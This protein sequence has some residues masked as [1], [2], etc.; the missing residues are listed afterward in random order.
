MR[1]TSKWVECASDKGIKDA[2]SLC[3]NIDV[4]KEVLVRAREDK[5]VVDLAEKI[6]VQCPSER[7]CRLKS[8]VADDYGARAF[9][10]Y[11]IGLVVDISDKG[12]F[13]TAISQLEGVARMALES[14]YVMAV[15]N[16]SLKVSLAYM[17][18]CD[19]SIAEAG[20]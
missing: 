9:S 20:Y 8:I 15:A 10:C 2:Y 11:I 7:L 17:M 19:D 12:R 18:A 5:E 3:R 14:I 13:E 4:A 6:R 16:T 1:R